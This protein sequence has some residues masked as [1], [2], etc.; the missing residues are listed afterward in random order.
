MD[1]QSAGEW[2]TK[3]NKKYVCGVMRGHNALLFSS[4]FMGTRYEINSSPL[5]FPTTDHVNHPQDEFLPMNTCE[6]E[7]SNQLK[8]KEAL[9]ALLSGLEQGSAP[10]ACILGG[11]CV[12]EALKGLGVSPGTMHDKLQLLNSPPLPLNPSPLHSSF[13]KR[14][15]GMTV[16]VVG[17]G[18]IGCEALRLLGEIGVGKVFILDPDVVERSNLNRQVLF[19]YAPLLSP[20]PLHCQYI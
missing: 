16:A 1:A 20:P 19:R 13:S 11:W 10:L 15:S 8:S 5:L 3:Q 2:C 6:D 12:S 18:A 17:S 9:L 4:A 7:K 14:L